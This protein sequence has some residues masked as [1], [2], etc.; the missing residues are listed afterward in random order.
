VR[1]ASRRV[2]T[3]GAWALLCVVVAFIY[4]FSLGPILIT[5]AVSFNETNRSLFPPR[6]WS[7]RWWQRALSPEWIDPLWFSLKLG[8][9]T[10]L[11]STLLALPL[12]FALHRYRFRGR[13]AL[14]ALALGPL[15]LP[16]LVTGVG[17]LQMFQYLGWREYIGF[18]ALLAGHLVICLP[19]A[20]RTVT[21][22][23]QTLPHNVELAA[24]SLGATRWQTLRYIVFPLIKSGLIAGAVF[25]FIHSF[26]DVNLSLFLASPGQQPITVKILAFLEFGFAPTLAAVSVITLIL[27]LVL[28]AIVERLSGLGDFIYGDRDRG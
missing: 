5:A 9:I 19:F 14:I 3:S 8:G 1:I 18:G 16:T 26:T 27:P 28:V 25:A 11:L 15:M 2:E 13:E 7:L 20:V 24:A 21:I 6:G 10:A 4:L 23:L 17:L 22:S 12:A